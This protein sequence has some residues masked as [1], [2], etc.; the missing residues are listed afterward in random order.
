MTPER[1]LDINGRLV[2]AYMHQ[3][4]ITDALPDLDDVTPAEA[5]EAARIAIDTPGRKNANGTTSIHMKFDRTESVMRSYAY[6]VFHKERPAALSL[7]P[8]MPSAFRPPET[9]PEDEPV[10]LAT[11]GG[12]IGEA[13]ML[14]NE[15]TGQQEW[16]WV[17]RDP[18]GKERRADLHFQLLG[19][20]PMPAHPDPTLD[21]DPIATV[22][23]TQQEHGADAEGVARS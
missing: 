15:D 18:Q 3:Q 6:A 5:L 17:G 13:W 2:L 7:V 12:W 9:A 1:A 10:I 11:S 14:V 16:W 21:N 8:P 23:I 19:W 4:N 20:Q 22:P